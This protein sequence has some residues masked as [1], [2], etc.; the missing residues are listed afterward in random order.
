ML[1]TLFQILL[2]GTLKSFVY[3]YAAG[4]KSLIYLY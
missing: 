3:N 2:N 1:L 4:N